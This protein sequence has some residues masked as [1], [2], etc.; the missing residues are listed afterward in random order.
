MPMKDKMEI[1]QLDSTHPPYTVLPCSESNF[2]KRDRITQMTSE[3]REGCADI[4]R[5]LFSRAMLVSMLQAS[6]GST[7]ENG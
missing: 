2:L 3:S 4:G 7:M 1:A 5:H 6:L